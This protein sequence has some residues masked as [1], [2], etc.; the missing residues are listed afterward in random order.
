MKAHNGMRPHD[1]VVLLKIISIR[2][3]WLNK[4]LSSALHI[5][6]S[7]ISESLN[8]SRI[9]GLISP[10]KKKVMKSAFIKFIQFG[11]RYVFPVEPGSMERGIPTGHSAPILKDYFL[12]AEKYVWPSRLG[13]EKGFVI[14]PL[15]PN[16]VLAA[17]DNGQLYDMLALIDAIRA[18]KTRECEKAIELLEQIFDKPYAREYN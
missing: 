4:D 8:R 7:E 12:S 16:Q 6:S 18:G 17:G 14:Q 13:K 9:S 2:G 10:D 1:I 15:Y 11:L 5:S 3:E